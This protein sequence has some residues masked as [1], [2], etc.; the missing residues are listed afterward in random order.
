MFGKLLRAAY[1]TATL[2]VAVAADFATMG[3]ALTDRDE[4]YTVEKAK[5]I[6]DDVLTAGDD[7][8]E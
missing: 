3:G 7:L 6:V 5:R 1:D 8:A 4:P 2:P